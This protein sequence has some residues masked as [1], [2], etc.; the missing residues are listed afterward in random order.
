M[1]LVLSRT[2]WGFD[3]WRERLADV[4]AAG[5]DCVC[6]P[7][8]QATDLAAVHEHGLGLVAQVFTF[9]RTVDDHMAML[10]EGLE[11]AAASGARHAVVQGG[12]DGW[13]IEDALRFLRATPDVGIPVLH[14]THRGRILFN[15]WVT[16]RVLHAL[17]DLRLNADLSHWVVV[18]ESLRLPDRVVDAVA[19]VARQ[20]DARVGWEEGPQVADPRLPRF[21][22]HVEAFERWWDAIWR[23]QEAQGADDLVVMP[24]F[25][26]PPYQP[27]DVATGEPLADVAELNRWMADQLRRRWTPNPTDR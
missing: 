8:Q 3:D 27:I 9:G 12:R 7:V 1:R 24:E 26:P 13:P 4:A 15:P 10:R 16:E 6:V 25:G 23:A 19:S 21:A 22:E 14:E 18:G 17:P 5:F 20:V 11:L 2:T